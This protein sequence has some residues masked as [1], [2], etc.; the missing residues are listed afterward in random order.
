MLR[1]FAVLSLWLMMP[2][3]VSAQ[4][5]AGIA[6]AID[7]DTLAMTSA[8]IRLQGID[9]PEARQTCYRGQEVWACGNE[10]HAELA[11]LVADKTV[12][13]RQQDRD[14]YGRVVAQ[15]RVDG[16]DL[17][18]RLV[19]A[20]LVVVLPSGD[21]AYVAAEAR[22][23]ALQV[24]IW[25]S[26]FESPAAYRLANSL[27]EGAAPAVV[28]VRERSRPPATVAATEQPVFFPNCAAARAAGY[29][30]IRRGQPGY[31]S[32]LDADND[33]IACEPYRN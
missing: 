13:C 22:M 10:A 30:P 18:L 3:S 16:H 14:R 23:R 20:G 25:G 33:G 12:I 7:G 19:E 5:I 21:A 6:R 4:E 28:E 15:C 8:R 26:R 9:A 24:G 11:R 27:E 2:A 17:A 1:F 32:A 29:A 31:R